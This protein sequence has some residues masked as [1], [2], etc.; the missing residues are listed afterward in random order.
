MMDSLFIP[1]INWLLNPV[2]LYIPIIIREP[3]HIPIIFPFRLFIY[4]DIHQ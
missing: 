3:H 4:G 1:M 2:Y